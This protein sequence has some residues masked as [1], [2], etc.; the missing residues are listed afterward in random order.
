M[1]MFSRNK[2]ANK[3]AEAEPAVAEPESLAL[4]SHLDAIA[5]VAAAERRLRETPPEPPPAPPVTSVPRR[6]PSSFN[7][8]Q[9]LELERQAPVVPKVSPRDIA[10]QELAAARAEEQEAPVGH[11]V[12]LGKKWAHE[13]NEATALKALR[14][15]QLT[16]LNFL[17]QEIDLDGAKG[18]AAVLEEP[19]P[20]P[21]GPWIW[22]SRFSDWLR[23][24]AQNPRARLEP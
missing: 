11:L 19:L 9:A 6:R 8:A 2:L 12:Q 15:S 4:R 17:L 3:P 18:V 7:E 16:G 23:R 13:L 21:V 5:R 14:E 1:R 24:L 20:E 10:A 22:R